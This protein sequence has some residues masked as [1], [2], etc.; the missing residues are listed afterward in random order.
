MTENLV[1]QSGHISQLLASLGM[2]DFFKVNTPMYTHNW[3]R[4]AGDTSRN[5][6]AV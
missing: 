1:P 4:Y 2:T 3:S 6:S 5:I